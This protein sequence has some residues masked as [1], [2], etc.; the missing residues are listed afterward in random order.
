MR[1]SGFGSR[2][3]QARTYECIRFRGRGWGMRVTK[4]PVTAAACALLIGCGHA[5]DANPATPGPVQPVPS[6]PAGLVN[7]RVM[8][9]DDAVVGDWLRCGKT[10]DYVSFGFRFM[11]EGKWRR[12]GATIARPVNEI[13]CV[14]E[15][16]PVANTPWRVLQNGDL[17]VDDG[18]YRFR[19]IDNNT[20]SSFSADNRERLYRRMMHAT[21]APSCA[22][23]GDPCEV[24]GQCVTG[25][26]RDGRCYH[27]PLRSSH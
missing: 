5:P 4:V 11:P 3:R 21:D 25:E 9:E 6:V 23:V 20:L 18:R 16:L 24:G 2:T 19:R 13:Y 26:C 14:P 12:V 22:S 1:R 17:E 7:S 15:D 8:Q 27:D 10:C